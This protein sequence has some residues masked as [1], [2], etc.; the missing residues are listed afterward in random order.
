MLNPLLLSLI[1]LLPFVHG[2]L[3]VKLGKTTVSGRAVSD[4]VDFFGGEPSLTVVLG[5]V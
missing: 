1:S 5:P 3:E 2:L 4:K